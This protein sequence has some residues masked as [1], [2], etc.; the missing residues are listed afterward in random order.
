MPPTLPAH[1]SNLELNK[2]GLEWM[3]EC[4]VCMY[5]HKNTQKLDPFI[6]RS[7]HF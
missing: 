5:R 6:T 1:N 4:T 3:F 7:E 2:S